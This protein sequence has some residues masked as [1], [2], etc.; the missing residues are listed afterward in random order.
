MTINRLIH[1]AHRKNEINKRRRRFYN[2]YSNGQR[3]FKLNDQAFYLNGYVKAKVDMKAMTPIMRE[4]RKELNVKF[5][6]DDSGRIWSLTYEGATIHFK[7]FKKFS[8]D[9]LADRIILG[10]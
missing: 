1:L 10:G 6:W 7:E 4:I 3:K 5:Q 2:H 8:D 9:Y